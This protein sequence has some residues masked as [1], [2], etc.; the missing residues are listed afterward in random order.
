MRSAPAS[1]I[2]MELSCWDTWEMGILKLLLRVMKVATVPSVVPPMPLIASAPPSR[3]IRA[4]CRL[5]RLITAGIRI[6]A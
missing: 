4:Y 2:T 1:A 5:P 3:A 6:L